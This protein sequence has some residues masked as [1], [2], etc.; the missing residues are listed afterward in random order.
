MTLSGTAL[1]E[2]DR[3]MGTPHYMAPEQ[4]EHPT[5]VDH[6]ADIYS[7]GVV[8]YEMLTG[9]LPQGQFT[10]PSRKAAVDVRLDEVVLGALT[11][12]PDERYQHAREVKTDVETIARTLTSYEITTNPV[13]ARPSP[14]QTRRKTFIAGLAAA[15]FLLCIVGLVAFMWSGKKAPESPQAET[16]FQPPLEPTKKPQSPATSLTPAV[17]NIP[18]RD[19]MANSNQI[20][21]TAWYNGDLLQCWQ[22]S[23]DKGNDLR[24]LPTR[25]QSFA[26]TL[27]DVR[28]L[29]AVSREPHTHLPFAVEGIHIGQKCKQIHFLHSA[30]NAAFSHSEQIAH[31][32]VHLANGEEHAI[33]IVTGQD[34]IDWHS[35]VPPNSPL[36]IAWEGDNQKTRKQADGSKKIRLYKSTWENPTPEVEV[37]TMDIIELRRGPSPFLIALTVE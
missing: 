22:G 32:I 33:P 1:T 19:P 5:E 29:I 10:P 18:L 7:L 17:L 24:E 16:E 25:L 12:E 13:S 20:D 6:R 28:G 8:F 4:R 21:L 15:L 11:K 37:Q 3:V 27:F 36:V 34:V 31:Y 14:K 23:W 9:E 26:G 35:D 2:P 30:F